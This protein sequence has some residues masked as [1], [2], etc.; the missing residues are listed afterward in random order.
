MK[1]KLIIFNIHAGI[2]EQ[3]FIER[4]SYY[5]KLAQVVKEEIWLF[6][7]E[8]NTSECM[9]LITKIICNR[10]F[11]G[12]A[13][14]SNLKFLAACNPYKVKSKT[15]EVGLVT[16]RKSSSK[17]LHIVNSLPDTLIE[18]IWDYGVLSNKDEKNYIKSMI[19][20]LKFQNPEMVQ[21]LLFVC[22]QFI[23][24]IDKESSS[25]S[26]R[27]IERFR[28][29]YQWFY[30][31]IKNRPPSFKIKKNDSLFSYFRYDI[32][33]EHK[34]IILSVIVCYY[35]RI[36]QAIQRSNFLDELS[37]TF[38]IHKI[39]FTKQDIQGVYEEEQKEYL[40]RMNVP[41][42]IAKNNALRE[43]VFATFICIMNKIPVF[44][45]GKPGCSK[46]LTLQLMLSSLLGKESKDSWFKELPGL[47][48]ITYQGIIF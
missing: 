7:D 32:S 43:N 18:H 11:L 26:L 46:T 9:Y 47:F 2:I 30:L 31:N 25:V 41:K 42:G 20:P 34:C 14:P 21:D 4:V 15:L 39:K 48:A 45:C 1:I 29:L 36:S 23:R 35:L 24:Y 3:E 44:I 13:L 37:N 8:F 17:L 38:K 27:D 6:F 28:V 22:H 16:Q 10:T 19:N 40:N 12:H 33:H 5:I